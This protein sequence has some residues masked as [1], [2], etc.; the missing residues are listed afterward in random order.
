MIMSY[1][2][3]IRIN[4]RVFG[5]FG[6]ELEKIDA[7]TECEASDGAVVDSTAVEIEQSPIRLENHSVDHV[8]TPNNPSKQER[9]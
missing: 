4:V 9:K 7:S 2:K 6:A 3:S 1:F 5:L 8:L